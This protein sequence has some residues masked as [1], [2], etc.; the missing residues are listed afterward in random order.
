MHHC[1]A[2]CLPEI[3]GE[4]AY[5]IDPYN[6]NVDLDELLSHDVAFPKVLEIYF[7]AFCK[8]HARYLMWIFLIYSSLYFYY[9]F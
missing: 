3:F 9:S 8:N 5:W 7:Q 6:T 1:K 2:S 4:V